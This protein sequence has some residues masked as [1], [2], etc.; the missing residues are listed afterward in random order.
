MFAV[1]H[2]YYGCHNM[3]AC[4]YSPSDPDPLKW[5]SSRQALAD[6]ATFHAYATAQYSLTP[7]NKWVSFGGSYPGML[8]GWFRVMY[9]SLVHASISSSAPVHAKLDMTEYYD[10]A[11]RAYSL[12]SVGGSDACERAIRTGHATIGTMMNSSSGRDRLAQL[13]DEVRQM[14]AEWLKTRSG[15]AQFPA[16]ASPASRRRATTRAARPLAATSPRSAA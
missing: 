8:A 7:R 13:F 1:E 6:L 4:P 11:A 16:T 3:S 15:Q 10:I 14:G 12:P 9:P 2:R 5:L